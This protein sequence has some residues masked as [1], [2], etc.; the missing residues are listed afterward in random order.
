VADAL[1]DAILHH[2]PGGGLTDLLVQADHQVPDPLCF[3]GRDRKCIISC[4][5]LH[6]MGLR[7][8]TYL[9]SIQTIFETLD[10]ERHGVIFGLLWLGVLDY[11]LWPIANFLLRLLL[12]G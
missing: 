10:M 12:K 5:S 3:L 4:A 8:F 1:P 6:E 9:M 7:R 11:I 2:L